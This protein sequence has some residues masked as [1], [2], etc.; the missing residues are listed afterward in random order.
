[1]KKIKMSNEKYQQ[2]LDF[3]DFIKTTN[4]GKGF[5]TYD[6]IINFSLIAPELRTGEFNELF[7]NFDPKHPHEFIEVLDPEMNDINKIIDRLSM[8][9]ESN[10]GIEDYQKE[11]V[12]TL[13]T[14]KENST[15]RVKMNHF[16]KETLMWFLLNENLLSALDYFNTHRGQ[17]TFGVSHDDLMG[18]LTYEDIAYVWLNPQDIEEVK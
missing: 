10:G 7:S 11:V 5:T 3:Y 16:Q 18:D 9:V 8:D 14:L 12:S 1:M 6:I 2:F 17:V 15:K 13:K 4:N